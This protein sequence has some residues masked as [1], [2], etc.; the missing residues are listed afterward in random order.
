MPSKKLRKRRR[1]YR[2]YTET[3]VMFAFIILITVLFAALSYIL[4]TYDFDGSEKAV[5]IIQPIYDYFNLDYEIY[6]YNGVSRALAFMPLIGCCNFLGFLTFARKDMFRRCSFL[7]T[8]IFFILYIASLYF[9]IRKILPDIIIPIEKSGEGI[10]IEGRSHPFI[11]PTELVGLAILGALCSFVS[12]IIFRIWDCNEFFLVIFYLLVPFF[13]VIIMVL[14]IWIGVG[15]V[16]DKVD[17]ALTRRESL[18]SGYTHSRET[19]SYWNDR[20]DKI[21]IY[22][23]NGTDF[24]DTSGNY[25]GYSDDNGSTITE[26]YPW[27]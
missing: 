4:L 8:L 16:V 27:Q 9:I 3:K 12:F 25:V 10:I 1:R 22:T 21:D 13:S 20:G 5:S 23:E 17:G 11:S 19:Y 18:G 24:Y 6:G 26:A 14:T 2:V 7:F 15:M